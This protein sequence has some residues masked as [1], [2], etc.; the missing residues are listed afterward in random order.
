MPS[1]YLPCTANL[2]DVKFTN[3]SRKN[4]QIGSFDATYAD[5]VDITNGSIKASNIQLKDTYNSNVFNNFLG[6][7]I[8][9]KNIELY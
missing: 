7:E 1:Y 4:L 2:G 3:I 9:S 8:R 5:N 6:C